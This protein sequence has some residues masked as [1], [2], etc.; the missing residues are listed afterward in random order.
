[1]FVVLTVP[2]RIVL[3]TTRRGFDT[4]RLLCLFI[5]DFPFVQCPAENG[6]PVT[7]YSLEWMED[8]TF[9]EVLHGFTK[10]VS[11]TFVIDLLYWWKRIYLTHIPSLIPLSRFSLS[12]L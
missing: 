2:V 9:V 12:A 11:R 10:S 4:Q 6:T 5:F 3:S 7:G 1:M 8:G